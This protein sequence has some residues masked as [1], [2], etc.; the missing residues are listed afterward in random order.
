VTIANN[1]NRMISA[2][3]AL[4]IE[5]TLF[6]VSPGITDMNSNSNRSVIV[7][8]RFQ[9]ILISV[10]CDRSPARNMSLSLG[11]FIFFTCII[12]KNSFKNY[13]YP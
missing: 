7:K 4:G 2:T 10:W 8:S 5:N 3:T 9:S 12:L 11:F 1:K 13:R 6:I